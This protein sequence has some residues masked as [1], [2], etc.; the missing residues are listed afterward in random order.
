MPANVSDGTAE[1][2]DDQAPATLP[3][4]VVVA[5][6]QMRRGEPALNVDWHEARRG[7]LPGDRYVRVLRPQD[8]VFREQSDSY[9]TAGDAA[10]APKTGTGR[11]FNRLKRMLIGRPIP[12]ASAHEERLTKVKALAVLSSDAL[13]SVAY[14]TE[15]TLQVLVLAGAA[16]FGATIPISLVIAALLAIVAL[17]YRQTIHAYPSG[18]GA[19]IVARENLG[20]LPGLV[21]AASL[22]VDYILTV[23]VSVSAGVL[24]LISAFP[25]LADFS[26]WIGVAFIALITLGNL[27]GIRES[28]SIFAIPTYVFIFSMFALIGAG[29]VRLALG[30]VAATGGVPREPLQA[31]EGIGLFLILRA[32]A[33]GCTALTGVEAISNG[34]PA[35]KKPESRNAATT[36]MVMV[37][38][39]GTMFLGTSVLAHSYGVVPR[40]DESMISQLAEQVF[41]GRGVPYFII[42]M[43]TC[44]ILVLA[45]NT[46]FADFPRLGSILARD[47]FLPRQF[48][49]RGDR[50]AFST[51]I[52]VLAALSGLLYVAFKGQTDL[53]IPLYAVGVFISFTLSQ[54][55]MVRH[56]LRTPG[57]NTYS[58]AI[59]QHGSGSDGD[60]SGRLCGDEVYLWCVARDSHH[61]ASRAV[62]PRH[63]PALRPGAPRVA[64]HRR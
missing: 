31:V 14:A 20:T 9:L 38:L 40:A 61:P 11:A 54:G 50:L 51:G 28:G 21:A 1:A 13:S 46:S 55:G 24:A 42:Q 43:A 26:V 22:L 41:G 29:L 7:A 49:F 63:R 2:T 32:F 39:L 60:R 35:F 25:E 58:L 34:I 44:L 6:P 4:T 56:W 45:A 17:S 16:A 10:Y 57:R 3:P 52:I 33:S 30:D 64:A 47:G 23:S 37:A 59:T 18:G 12:S 27:R 19:Y 53:L 8:R 62:V 15:S 36:L 48:Q 5:R